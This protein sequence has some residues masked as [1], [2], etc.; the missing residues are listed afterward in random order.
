MPGGAPGPASDLAW[1]AHCSRGMPR[2]CS[3]PR[4]L[5]VPARAPGPL[6]LLLAAGWAEGKASWGVGSDCPEKWTWRC[7]RLTSALLKGHSCPTA[8]FPLPCIHRPATHT[9]TRAAPRSSTRKTLSATARAGLRPS[10][11]ACVLASVTPLACPLQLPRQTPPREK[12]GDWTDGEAGRRMEDEGGWGWGSAAGRRSR[13]RAAGG[14][15]RA[16]A[17]AS[18]PDVRGEGRRGQMGPRMGAPDIGARVG[19]GRGRG[20]AAGGGLWWCVGVG[21]GRDQD[22]TW[23]WGH[24]RGQGER[25]RPPPTCWACS[26]Y[27]TDT[28]GAIWR[29]NCGKAAAQT[30]LSTHAGRG[31]RG[32]PRNHAL[33]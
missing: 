2:G 22:W 28:M 3:D 30:T 33:A 26:P 32:H 14:G 6:A 9:H 27:V 12:E 21:G 17:S 1:R 16:S 8:L 29:Q 18:G 20:G 23:G 11:P 24:R 19:P 7:P 31:A 10:E 13:E 5:S 25:D 4:P 15:A